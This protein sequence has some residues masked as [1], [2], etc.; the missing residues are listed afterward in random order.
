[1]Q[2]VVGILFVALNQRLGHAHLFEPIDEAHEPPGC[3]AQDVGA[4]LYQVL[5]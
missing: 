4:C 5:P 2:I 1:M 3:G